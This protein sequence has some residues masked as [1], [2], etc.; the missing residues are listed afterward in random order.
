MCKMIRFAQLQ[1][2]ER[3]QL[4]QLYWGRSDATEMLRLEHQARDLLQAHARLQTQ[5][6]GGGGS[7]RRTGQELWQQAAG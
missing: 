2:E 3:A 7:T 6:S 4:Q 1:Q 5:T